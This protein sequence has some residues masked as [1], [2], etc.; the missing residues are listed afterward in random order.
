VGAATV[1]PTDDYG[2]ATG[3]PAEMPLPRVRPSRERIARVLKAAGN[4]ELVDLWSDSPVCPPEYQ[5][6]QYILGQLFNAADLLCV[7]SSA[8]DFAARTVGEWT[9]V[10]LCTQQFVVPNPLRKLA[11]TTKTGGESAHSRDATGPRRFVIVESDAGLTIDEQA[12]I[13]QFLR[14]RTS[15]PLAA[16]VMSGGKSLHAWF[17]CA[18]VTTDYLRRWFEIAVSLGADPRLWLP[19]Q[20]VRLPD[21]R[22]DNGA[23]QSLMF[24][25]PDSR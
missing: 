20:F 21:G 1:A 6:P 7:G 13:V 10:E 8:S 14:V 9:D 4:F 5:A 12:K 2:A 15:L 25:N 17:R 11:G 24:L 19:E 16:V 23:R 18:G 3:W 22:R